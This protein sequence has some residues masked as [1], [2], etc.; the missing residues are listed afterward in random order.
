[1]SALQHPALEPVEPIVSDLFGNTV[2][3]YVF[4]KLE[5]VTMTWAPSRYRESD[6]MVYI[7]TRI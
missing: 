4:L 6:H 5:N 1:L 2:A 3:L 7:R